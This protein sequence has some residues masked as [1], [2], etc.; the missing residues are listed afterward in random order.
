MA[1]ND[2]KMDDFKIFGICVYNIAVSTMKKSNQKTKIQRADS[3]LK[4][5]ELFGYVQNWI[6]EGGECEGHK[7]AGISK[8]VELVKSNP[9]SFSVDRLDDSKGYHLWNIQITTRHYNLGRKNATLEEMTH[10][11]KN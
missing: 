7:R 1:K 6:N 10:Y 9:A 11:L 8:A 2:I 4:A 3:T 5:S